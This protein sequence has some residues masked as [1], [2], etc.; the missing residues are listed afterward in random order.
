[1]RLKDLA[2]AP[3][4]LYEQGSTGRR[5]VIEA[6]QREGL[7]PHVE[8]ETTTT[9]LIV[10]MVEAGLGVSIVPLL[11]SGVVTRGRRVESRPVTGRMRPIDSGI[12]LRKGEPLSDAA[13]RF[14]E[15]VEAGWRLG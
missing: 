1:M 3:L 2:A 15:F 8:M 10:R 13:G 4:I 12:L 5:H 7:S 11:P 9:D 14:V 6:F